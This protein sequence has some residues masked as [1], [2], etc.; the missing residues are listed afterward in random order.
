MNPILSLGLI[1]IGKE[2]VEHLI[3][4]KP[5]PKVATNVESVPFS[6][7]LDSVQA[8]S[9]TNGL[10][11]FLKD[12]G[13]Q[14]PADLENALFHLSQQLVKDPVFSQFSADAFR[15]GTFSL[16]ADGRGAVH[17]TGPNGQQVEFLSD[18]M[19]GELAQ[20]IHQLSL[21]LQ[22]TSHAPDSRL[23]P[24]ARIVESKSFSGDPW[25]LHLKLN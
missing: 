22:E 12:S 14:N 9:P 21:L 3:A 15:M 13:I 6:R 10:E 8:P 17:L 5:L 4:K 19:T 18:S 7:Y 20:K 1:N 2:A 16:Q 11:Q 23:G 24:L 25:N